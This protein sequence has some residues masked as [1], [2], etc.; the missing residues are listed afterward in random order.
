M[1]FFQKLEQS[2]RAHTG[3]ENH[4]VE[5]A[6]EQVRRKGQR[7]RIVLYRHFP[8]R[9]SENRNAPRALISRAI[10]CARRLSKETKRR[11]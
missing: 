10:S 1:A 5:A 7:G 11:D 9:R 4:H 6:G 3:E 2:A 8:Q